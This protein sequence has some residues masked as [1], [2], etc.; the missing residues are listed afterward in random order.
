MAGHFS[1]FDFRNEFSFEGNALILFYFA[2]SK[3]VKPF[4]F[5]QL[6]WTTPDPKKKHDLYENIVH[7]ID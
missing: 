6:Y 7:E 2:H 3:L 1:S 4:M 5:Y